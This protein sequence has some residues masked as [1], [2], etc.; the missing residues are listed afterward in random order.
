M[1]ISTQQIFNIANTSMADA[2]QAMIKTQEQLSTGKRVL[3]PSDDPVASTKILALNEELAGT[4]Q[5]QT[6]ISIAKNDLT[7]EEAVLDGVLNIIQR[8]QELAVRAGNSATLSDSEYRSLANEVD[9]RVEELQSLMNSKNSNGDF[10][11]G[12]Y[13]ST[14]EPFIGSVQTGFKYVGD[15]GQKF[16]KVANNTAVASGDSGKDLFVDIQSNRPEV[17]TS[18]SAS[19][20]S[21]PAAQISIGTVVD[22]QVF[23]DFYPEDLVVSFNDD[24]ALLPAPPGKNF[25]ITERSTGRVVL[26]NEPYVSGAEINAAGLSFR[27]IGDPASENLPQAGDKFI[28]ESTNKQDLLT[29]VARFSEAMKNFD[30]EA[31]NRDVLEDTIGDTL[32]NL[33]N[34]QTSVLEVSSKIGARLNTLESTESIHSDATLIIQELISQLRDV[35]Y[36]EASTR[37]AAESLILQAA[38]TAF[39]RVSRLSLFERL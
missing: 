9:A 25:T 39:T 26:A 32:A 15:E 3:E 38:Q 1:R 10:I 2:N 16:I 20:R 35:D 22:R 4:K 37:L 33:S 8:I 19:N 34:A 13:K 23:N 24:S 5:Y 31:G 11:F 14:T 7:G 17:S 29:T 36:A 6:N 30:G 27:I 28:V 12:G 21:D 18:V